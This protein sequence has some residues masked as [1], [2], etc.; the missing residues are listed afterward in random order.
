[1]PHFDL[2]V[3]LG[4]ILSALAFGVMALFAWR[5][6]TWRISN[7]EIWRKEHIRDADERDKLIAKMDRVLDHVRW[8]TEELLG[9]R[10]LP[11]NS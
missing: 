8:Q 3:S 6:L 11:P 7:L 4:N 10:S 1:M 5:D 9:R 2:T